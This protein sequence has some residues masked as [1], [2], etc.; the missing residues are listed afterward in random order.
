MSNADKIADMM[1]DSA[2]LLTANKYVDMQV[3]GPLAVV[4]L[5]LLIIYAVRLKSWERECTIHNVYEY[6]T[7]KYR[8]FHRVT[9]TG[10]FL[11]IV[12][13]IA[14]SY[15]LGN[16]IKNAES[17]D[18]LYSILQ[19]STPIKCVQAVLIIALLVAR[20][21]YR[22][23]SYKVD[24]K[25]APYSGLVKVT[26]NYHIGQ[27]CMA[28]MIVTALVSMI[29]VICGQVMTGKPESIFWNSAWVYYLYAVCLGLGL[30]WALTYLGNE[31]A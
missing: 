8:I 30:Y 31:E 9:Q 16:M 23:D 10:L 12:T 1:S 29:G 13:V 18:V 11:T 24:K 2:N 20:L 19:L 7:R 25:H 27:I 4:G 14:V 3:C 21:K 26:L 17:A 5:I 6:Y 22:Y 15:W 28:F